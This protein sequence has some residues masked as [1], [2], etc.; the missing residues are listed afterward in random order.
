MRLRACG[1]TPAHVRSLSSVA[2]I[3]IGAKGDWALP[4]VCSLVPRSRSGGVV[5]G[6]R[7]LQGDHVEMGIP[8]RWSDAENLA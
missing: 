3:T 7:W 2:P 8:Q 1:T 4:G 6:R 5:S